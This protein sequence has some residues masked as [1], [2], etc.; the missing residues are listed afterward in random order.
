MIPKKNWHLG[1]P[2][3][4]AFKETGRSTLPSKK[5]AAFVKQLQLAGPKGRLLEG[6][7]KFVDGAL[8]PGSRDLHNLINGVRRAFPGRIHIRRGQVDGAPVTR[9]I[10]D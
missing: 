10:L 9:V 6:H 3:N 4:P 8:D 7:I 1:R 2:Y 5:V